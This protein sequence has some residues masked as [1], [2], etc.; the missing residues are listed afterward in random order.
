M[1]LKEDKQSFESPSASKN[2]ASYVGKGRFLSFSNRQG[3]EGSRTSGNLNFSGF[4][5]NVPIPGFQVLL[6]TTLKI[7]LMFIVTLLL[8]K[9]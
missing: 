4:L 6:H 8:S 7:M 9:S 1:D 3:P 2:F 5:P